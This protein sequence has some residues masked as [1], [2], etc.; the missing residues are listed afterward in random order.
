MVHRYVSDKFG[1]VTRFDLKYNNISRIFGTKM[2]AYFSLFG[3]NSELFCTKTL[4]SDYS[5]QFPSS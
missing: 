2:L 4:K 1:V 3:A 5:R